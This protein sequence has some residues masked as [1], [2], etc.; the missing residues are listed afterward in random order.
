MGANILTDM[1]ISMISLVRAGANRKEIVLKGEKFEEL[2][3]IEITKHNDELG[4][5]YGIV[6]SP[7]KEDSQGDMASADEIRKAAYGFMK[8]ASI[9]KAVDVE[10]DLKPV[11]AHICESWIVRK[12]DEIFL[13][14]EGAWAVGVKLEEEEL[15]AAVKKGELTGLSMYGTATR[16][17]KK[18][19]EA[20]GIAAEVAKA[21]KAVFVDMFKSNTNKED[22]LSNKDQDT[23]T[24]ELIK[25]VLGEA[26]KEIAGEVK[27]AIDPLNQKIAA[28][29]KETEGFKVELEKSKQNED[30]RKKD[31][32][33]AGGI[34]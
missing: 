4:V 10:H 19:E 30:V 27:K 7:N 6:Y 28:L 24:Q 25:S 12:G 33:P 15:L 11:D 1:K 34:L 13:E 22:D 5:A 8:H 23:K 31:E 17:Q 9:A 32:S 21:V 20:K 14:E 26:T 2:R 29:E 18:D 3:H 16:V